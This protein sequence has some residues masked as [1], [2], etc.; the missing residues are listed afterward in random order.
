VRVLR[1]SPF[2]RC[3]LCSR[4]PAIGN[5]LKR[6]LRRADVFRVCHEN[7]KRARPARQPVCCAQARSL[8]KGA[9]SCSPLIWASYLFPPALTPF[10]PCQWSAYAVTSLDV[11][12]TSRYKRRP[13]K[14]LMTSDWSAT[15]R[16]D[17]VA[18]SEGNQIALSFS[19]FLSTIPIYSFM[20]TR[21]GDAVHSSAVFAL[22]M[23]LTKR[24]VAA[25]FPLSFF[26]VLV[27]SP[28]SFRTCGVFSSTP[29]QE[30]DSFCFDF[31]LPLKARGISTGPWPFKESFNMRGARE[32]ELTGDLSWLLQ[33]YKY[34]ITMN[35]YSKCLM[36]DYSHRFGVNAAK[37]WNAYTLPSRRW[38]KDISFGANMADRGKPYR[39]YH[40]LPCS[41]RIHASGPLA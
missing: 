21:P 15:R 11:H 29:L 14:W 37:R 30:P 13:F 31:S 38:G 9:R 25:R 28:D 23:F 32:T 5:T 12:P 20:Q 39:A 18:R 2:R 17:D 1:S 27:F 19:F 41:P 16:L 3:Y 35:I 34:F 6:S 26:L 22:R 40:G 8:K 36:N 10:Q 4:E 33:C 24:S 7:K